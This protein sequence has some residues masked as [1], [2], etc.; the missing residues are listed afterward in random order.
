MLCIIV[1]P[2]WLV[3]TKTREMLIGPA[4]LA[5]EKLGMARAKVG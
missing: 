1:L 3:V 2:A 5:K 4:D